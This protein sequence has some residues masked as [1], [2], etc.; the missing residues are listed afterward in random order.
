MLTFISRS[1]PITHNKISLIIVFAFSFTLSKIRVA[2]KKTGSTNEHK[3]AGKGV[4]S[5]S[6]IDRIYMHLR[7]MQVHDDVEPDN[8]DT[9]RERKHKITLA[10][11]EAI[12]VC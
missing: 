8:G 10:V 1:L 9:F 12:N 2:K 5:V 4:K 3:Q 6:G 11:V 7:K